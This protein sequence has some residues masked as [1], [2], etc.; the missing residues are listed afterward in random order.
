M[1]LYDFRCSACDDLVEMRLNMSENDKPE[2][3]PCGKCGKVGTVKQE[4][5]ANPFIDSVR[6]GITKPDRTFQRDVLNRIHKNTARSNMDKS[7]FGLGTR[8]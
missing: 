3:E 7:K 5:G 2:K 4:L 6:L 8:A 1:P